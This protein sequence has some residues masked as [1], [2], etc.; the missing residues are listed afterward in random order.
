[1][2]KDDLYVLQIYLLKNIFCDNKKEEQNIQKKE[3][4]DIIK[5]FSQFTAI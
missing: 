3:L 4:Y 5:L 1:M 2:I